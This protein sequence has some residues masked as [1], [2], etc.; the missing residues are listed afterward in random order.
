[1]R[2]ARGI[3]TTLT[4]FVHSSAVSVP[5]LLLLPRLLIPLGLLSGQS[6]V[7]SEYYSTDLGK[8]FSIPRQSP[9]DWLS[10]RVISSISPDHLPTDQWE[11]EGEGLIESLLEQ[12]QQQTFGIFGKY[13][14]RDGGVARRRR[15]SQ[16]LLGRL[17]L[18]DCP[19]II[20]LLIS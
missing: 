4:L 12:L 20:E 16:W 19:S 7:F 6:S 10:T 1:M 17:P 14:L 15:L 11:E 8:A 3:C 2:S 9:E 13:V 5:F 18:T